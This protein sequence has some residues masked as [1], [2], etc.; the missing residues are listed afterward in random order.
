MFVLS[1]I[2]E[3]AGMSN[4]AETA[5]LAAHRAGLVDGATSGAPE[6]SRQGR[7]VELLNCGRPVAE[8]AAIMD[9]PPPTGA[10]QISEPRCGRAD[11]DSSPQGAPHGP[12]GNGAAS[13]CMSVR[14]SSLT[15]GRAQ[16]VLG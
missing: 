7:I 3:N 8:I 1:A 5:P 6:V 2:E 4:S 12:A 15:F 16:F 14:G 10:P 13:P 11:T 9:R